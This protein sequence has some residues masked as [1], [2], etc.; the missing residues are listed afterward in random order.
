MKYSEK[1]IY[2]SY[3]DHRYLPRAVA[4]VD[5][6]RRAGSDDE[7]WICCLTDQ[8]FAAAKALDLPKVRAVPLAE[9]EA[10]CP[11]LLQVKPQRET[12]EYY[13]TCT[14]LVM[15]Y[16]F[17][18]DPEVQ[19]V[20]YLDSDLWFFAHPAPVFEHIGDAPVAITPH[21]FAPRLKANER[22]GVFNVGWVTFRRSEE[23]LKCLKWWADSCLEWC[24]GRIEGDR[25]GDQRYLEKFSA[26]A[27]NTKIITFKGCNTAPWNIE[28][29]TVRSDSGRLMVDEDPLVVFHFHGIKRVMRVFYFNNHRAYGAPCPRLVR[30]EMYRPYITSLLKAEERVQAVIPVDEGN[31]V[32][33]R[34]GRFL[35]IDIKNMARGFR[36]AAFQA[37]DL[38]TMRPIFVW[39]SSVF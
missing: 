36:T 24:Y 27:P 29:Y 2:C 13:Y 5:S 6:L 15:S 3:C 34:S 19:A 11:R 38:V 1:H 7:F 9:L 22:F 28:N 39:H 35:G 10:A 18:C 33:L 17:E 12:I 21:N 37:A 30:N 20:T 25:F 31:G 16:V 26:V 23:G 8:C 32:K 14:P 4:L